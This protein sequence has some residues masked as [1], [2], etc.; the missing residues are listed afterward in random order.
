M[1][2]YWIPETNHTLPPNASHRVVVASFVVNDKG[3]V[4]FCIRHHLFRS[5][6]YTIKF[7]IWCWSCVVYQ[8]LVV[9][10][11]SGAFKG[12]GVWKLPTGTV[13]EVCKLYFFLLHFLFLLQKM[14]TNWS[15]ILCTGWR[16][17]CSCNQGSERRGWGMFSR[18]WQHMH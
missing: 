13:E 14:K 10:E 17:I 5:I 16:Y 18:L 9:Q 12:T 7:L 8:L 15:S 11:K 4:G 2:V 1:L 3:E 6:Y